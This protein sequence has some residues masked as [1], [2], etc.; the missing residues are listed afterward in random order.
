[1]RRRPDPS[2]ESVAP[3][4]EARGVATAVARFMP[5]I[6]LACAAL[7]TAQWWVLAR[8]PWGPP[9]A[10]PPPYYPPP[11]PAGPPVVYYQ[12][13]PP[14]AVVVTPACACADCGCAPCYGCD[15]GGPGGCMCDLN[16]CGCGGCGVDC[17]A[18]PPV[19]VGDG[20]GSDPASLVRPGRSALLQSVLGGL[21]LLLP[22]GLLWIW[23]RRR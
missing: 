6:L 18:V 15:C 20:G 3:E 23:R 13:M 8:G 16:G 17:A 2:R 14:P 22:I 9:G 12:P 21:G 10:P 4:S 5:L 19:T 1:V 11:Y 7:L